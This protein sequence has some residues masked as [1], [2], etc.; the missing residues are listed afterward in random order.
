MSEP[1][2]IDPTEP[3]R[4]GDTR[5]VA[6]VAIVA[7]LLQWLAT[8]PRWLVH[9]N[10]DAASYL[11]QA[12]SGNMLWSSPT[13][14]AHAVLQYLYLGACALARSIGGTPADGFRLLNVLSFGA[15]AGV[16][17]AAAVQLL[18]SRL[19]AAL[20]VGLWAT[21]FVTMFLTFTLEDNI[22]FMVPAALLFALFASRAL[23]W[24]WRDSIYAGLLASACVLLSVQ[25][26]LYVVPTFFFL[27]ALPRPARLGR[28]IA[29]GA[30]A[31]VAF[32]AGIA[33]F[34]V[35]FLAVCSLPWR[36]S[37]AHLM[38]RPTSTF[39]E[40][41]MALIAQLLDV[42]ASL[43]TIGIAA[44]LHLFQNKRPLTSPSALLA[45]GAAIMALQ[46]A[47][48]VATALW[49]RRGRRWLPFLFASVLFGMTVMMSLYRD[50]EYAYLKRTDF[51][52]MLSAFLVM[53]VLHGI[54]LPTGWRRITAGA[55]GLGIAWQLA[56]GLAWRAHEVASYQTL[57]TTIL[58]KRLP[59]YHGL[60]PEGSF[61]RH[62]RDLRRANPHAC[63]FIF[64]FEEV[65]H[66]RWNPDITGC[67]WS[68]LP[69]PKVAIA[70][71]VMNRWPRSLDALDPAVAKN[72][73][74]GCEWYSP[75]AQKTLGI[76]PA[77][78]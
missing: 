77:A 39:P 46:G 17:A 4:R 58:G 10:W 47:A 15:T 6:A 35:F 9:I 52:P 68:E 36:Q 54:R 73:A 64:D 24:R 38:T 37:L 42:A 43:R 49:A 23:R 31:G 1:V 59:G 76:A 16:L 45:L 7:G 18:K 57:D 60:P 61:L 44:S 67:I 26:L 41:K 34:V 53:A 56:T 27:V 32:A 55:V 30:V 21:A 63:S 69:R 70:P 29:D 5:F 12:A 33:L 62:Y 66:G 2:E 71:A 65:K 28:R 14:T 78:K 8:S 19:L 3:P 75:A 20:V 74:L 51:V 25:G 48:V 11:H 22:V 72:T 40:S 13:W 50:V